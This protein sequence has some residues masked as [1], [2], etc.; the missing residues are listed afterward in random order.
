MFAGHAYVARGT[1]DDID[2]I[3]TLLS[4]N[5]IQTTGNPDLYIRHYGEFGIDDARALRERAALRAIGDR[6]IFVIAA[7]SINV[8]A[9]NALLKTL[10]EPPGGAL[11]FFLHPAP[12]TLL[13]TVRSRVQVLSLPKRVVHKPLVDVSS[14]LKAMPTKRLDML[15]P[16]LEKDEDPVKPGGHGAGRRDFGEILSFLSALEK[17]LE[18]SPSRL[19]AIYRARRYIGDRGALVKPLLEQVALLI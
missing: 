18:A 7:D 12:D 5:G 2:S 16:L 11:F 10:E 1:A 8:D 9:Q 15:K 6:R 19:H 13:P 3:L 4:E 14:F 17:R